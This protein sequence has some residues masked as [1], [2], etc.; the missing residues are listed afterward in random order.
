M[1]KNNRRTVA[2]II[3]NL[4]MGGAEN[5]LVTVANQW[6][7][8]AEVYIITFDSGA[9]FF[10]IDKRIKIFPLHTTTTKWGYLSPVVNAAKRYFK[11]PKVIKKIAPNVTI[12]FMDTSIM[13]AFF[14][15]LYTKIPMIMVFQLTPAK[16]IMR[17][18]LFPLRRTLYPKADGMVVLTRDTLDIFERLN[19]KLPAKQFVIPNPLNRQIVNDQGLQREDVILGL[20]RLADQKQFDILINLFH[21][22][23]PTHWKLWIVGEGDKR[24]EL[25]GLIKKYQLQDKVTLWGAQ[26]NV[27]EFYAKAKIFALTSYYEGFC[28][29]LCEAMANGCACISFDC[30][31]GP[32]DSIE[33]NVNG[34]LVADQ[35]IPAFIKGMQ[36]LIQSPSDI[37]RLSF[38]ARKI[39]GK[40]DIE[41]LIHEWEDA[42][43]EVLNNR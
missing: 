34:I 4:L 29:A 9:T 42:V 2:F 26:I 40:L 22:L 18:L 10:T 33:N 14:A 32:A 24:T 21:Q 35:D 19:I 3:P 13:W 36:H 30:E 25:E 31:V 16:A 5:A 41:T 37:E 23:Q 27:S 43:E 7:E 20:G 38:N 17:P 11:L 12:P 15:R 39:I 6:V 1:T 28:I 8:T